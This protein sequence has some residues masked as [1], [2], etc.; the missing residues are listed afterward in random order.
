ML[1]GI[2]PQTARQ[3]VELDVDLGSMRTFSR[4][5]D[6]LEVVLRDRDRLR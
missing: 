2:R 4:V 1:T 6:A 3:L 5:A